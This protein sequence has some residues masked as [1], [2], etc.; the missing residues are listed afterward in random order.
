MGFYWGTPYPWTPSVAIK[1]CLP[2]HLA[3]LH[4]GFGCGDFAEL[5]GPC[6]VGGDVVVG[7]LAVQVEESQRGQRDGRF[8]NH[9]EHSAEFLLHLRSCAGHA[10]LN[11][12][13]RPFQP[14]GRAHSPRDAFV[15][16]RR[17]HGVFDQEMV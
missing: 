5:V 17:R 8:F 15:I 1:D 13:E 12:E 2:R 11:E 3:F 4:T 7:I 6:V 9:P 10:E 14:L 16:I